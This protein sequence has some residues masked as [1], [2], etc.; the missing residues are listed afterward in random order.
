MAF[1]PDEE[2]TPNSRFIPDDAPAPAVQQR[3]RPMAA[4]AGIAN[5]AAETLGLPA[6]ALQGLVN[7][8]GMAFGAA[9][10]S[11]GRPDLAPG[12][13]NVPGGGEFYKNLLRRTGIAGLSPD[14]PNPDSAT[15]TAAYDL[16]SRG[17]FIPGG[18]LPAAASMI[19]EKVAGPEWAGVGAMVPAAG[20]QAYNAARA[21]S[22]QAQKQRNTVRD[23][24][25]RAAR[26]E[27]YVI[28]PSQ[29]GGG[30]FE[31]RVES[32]AGKSATNQEAVL[33]NQQ[34]TNDLARRAIGLPDNTPLT[35][36]ALESKRT[37]FA[38]P[39]Q[40]VAQIS[41]VASQA[42]QKLR[43]FRAEATAHWR[44]YDVSAD[45]KAQR[46]AIEFG[47]KAEAAERYLDN[48]ARSLGKPELMTDLRQARANIAKTYDI[49]R[50][51]NLGDGNIDARVLGRALDKGK[52][53]SGGLATAAKFSEAFPQISRPTAGNPTPGVNSMEPIGAAGL[54][55]G[56]YAT[57]GAPG[58]AAAAIP[59][60]RPAARGALLSDFYQNRFT[61][62]NYGPAVNA[63]GTLQSIISGVM[64][65][66]QTNR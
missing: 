47:Q 64:A 34:V 18:V 11:V 39:Y 61:Q 58:L 35:V 55:M 46:S 6:A 56:G 16:A 23:N 36:Q 53:L 62:P 30:F 50:A 48:V 41:P 42:L 25:I 51:L 13:I 27:G 33:R 20:L 4:N 66:Q 14:N 57:M 65:D 32:L 45:P 38:V 7:I 54:G 1:E 60:I 17:G 10:T 9:A 3:S 21:P 40:K 26:E 31:N 15:G 59:Y 12:I 43:D 24:T 19:A 8:P 37:E 63:P 5:F 49:E 29:V 28:P 52:P 44:H 22:L 2:E